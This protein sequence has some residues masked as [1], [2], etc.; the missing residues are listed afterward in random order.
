M[1][2]LAGYSILI[3]D[4]EANML[5]MLSASLK[6]AGYEV[7]T[8]ADGKEGLRKSVDRVYDFI[9]CDLKM[10]EMDGL[11]FLEELKVQ[12]L[13]STVIMMSAFAT[14]DTAVQAMKSGAYDFITKPFKIDE[15]LCIL[16]KAA[17]RVK[18]K[19]ENL[20]LKNKVKELEGKSG[21]TSIVGE[22][23]T[24]Q[25]LL[26][27]TKK[28]AIYDTT[29]LITGESGTGKEL[30]ARGI[31]QHSGRKDKSFVTV[32]CGAI[33]A[34]LLESEFFG[35]VKGA[36]SGADANRK[37]LF[38]E[39]EGGVLFLDEIGELPLELQVKLL[40]VLQER[41]VRPVG[42]N[43]N[44]KIDVRILAA[45][46]KNLA[47]EVDRGL[48]R[49]DLYYRLNVIGLHVPPLRERKDDIALLCDHF[50][51]KFSKRTSSGCK[52]LSQDALR[53]LMNYDW[54][55]NVRELQNC[56]ERVVVLS[57]SE[58]ITNKDLPV[59]VREAGSEI[60]GDELF[61]TCSLKEGKVLLERLLISRVLK[62]TEGNKSQAAVMLEISY[63]SL[64]SKIK[65]LDL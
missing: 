28:V 57:A 34:N 18:L 1:I 39:A 52:Q 30:I 58:V 26:H 43:R 19:R 53:T 16:D 15:V 17:E 59:T 7:A 42:S 33:P 64:L 48:F 22:N 4:D 38:E 63:P 20:A 61:E 41:E 2:E 11:S 29:V 44:R 13:E 32:N 3:I 25:E 10:P 45:T 36:F 60:I 51:E 5:H 62:K 47:L 8:A 37:G 65:D 50:I 21:L 23:K 14:I 9:L 6:K 55:G 24:L 35:Y 27:L 54:P 46:A 56:M 31:H 12:G 40:R 49:Q